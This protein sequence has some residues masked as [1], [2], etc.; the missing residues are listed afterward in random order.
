M[1]M[2]R[3]SAPG[4]IL[5]PGGYPVSAGKG[6]GLPAEQG[7]GGEGLRGLDH[8]HPTGKHTGAGVIKDLAPNLYA[9]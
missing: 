5:R 6:G 3:D 4:P 2:L 9:S 7:E 1:L 8:T